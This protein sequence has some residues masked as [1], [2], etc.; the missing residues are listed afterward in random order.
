MYLYVYED[1][2]TY[3]KFEDLKIKDG[4]ETPVLLVRSTNV[5]FTSRQF[6]FTGSIDLSGATSWAIGD[7]NGNLYIACNDN[8]NGFNVSEQ[9]LRPGLLEIG[10]TE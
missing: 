5:T 6:R 1:G 4:Y 7:A 10:K 8:H 3:G 2:T 9:H